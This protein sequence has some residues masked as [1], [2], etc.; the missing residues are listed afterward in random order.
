MALDRVVDPR[1]WQKWILYGVPTVQF[2]SMIVSIALNGVA[3]RCLWSIAPSKTCPDVAAILR[4]NIFNAGKPVS[5]QYSYV[6]QDSRMISTLGI[7]SRIPCRGTH[8][9]ILETTSTAQE[10]DWPVS[11][12]GH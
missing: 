4:F 7:Y 12:D 1:R 10:K 8:S 5:P 6:G 11:A 9:G 2:T 3:I